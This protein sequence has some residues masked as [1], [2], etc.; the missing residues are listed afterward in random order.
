MGWIAVPCGPFWVKVSAEITSKMNSSTQKPLFHFFNTHL[1]NIAS[2]GAFWV[3]VITKMAS[4]M[5]SA[6]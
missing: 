6:T 5:N 3:R 1:P 4:E 2:C